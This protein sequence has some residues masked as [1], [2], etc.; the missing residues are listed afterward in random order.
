MP[1]KW[2]LEAYELS[3]YPEVGKIDFPKEIPI[4][5]AV[6]SKE[7]GAS[8]FIVDGGPQVCDYCGKSMFRTEVRTYT[9][10][11]KKSTKPKKT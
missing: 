2:Q 1:K 6:C 8:S 9:L 5:F 7:C 4:A 3:D 10:V 11:E